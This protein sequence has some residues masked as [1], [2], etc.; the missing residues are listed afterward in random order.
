MHTGS[1]LC[2]NVKYEIRGN[3][4]PGFYCH[5][6]LCRK[7]SGSAFASNII[8]AA[9]EFVIVSGEESLK[10]FSTPDGTH[11]YFCGNCGS[12]IVSRRDVLPDVVRVRMGTLDSPLSQGPGAH[13]YVGS[14]APW[15]EI[16]DQLP[17]HEDR[18]PPRG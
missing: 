17:Q 1:C 6:S 4:G 18:P 8:A 3:F 2:G 9:R 7:A 10:C 12:P 13:I 16:H 5:C 11:R 14:K 15:H